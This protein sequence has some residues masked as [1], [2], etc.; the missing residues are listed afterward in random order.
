MKNQV[1]IID[2]Q[3]QSE[4]VELISY[5]KIKSTGKSYVFYSKN[6]TVQNGLIKMY[7]LEVNG[8]TINE[9]DWN[10]LKRIMQGMITGSE[11]ADIEVLTTDGV[12][13]C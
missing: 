3:G 6:E 2:K 1:T 10:N 4:N 5:F 9:D 13:R 7:A 8:G 11:I 12:I